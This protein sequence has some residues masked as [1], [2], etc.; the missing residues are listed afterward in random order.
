MPIYLKTHMYGD[1]Y[2]LT[3]IKSTKY[4]WKYRSVW[5]YV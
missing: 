2:I 3:H 1:K 4:T 5:V